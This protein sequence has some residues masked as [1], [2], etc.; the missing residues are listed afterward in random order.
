MFNKLF[1]KKSQEYKTGI[2]KLEGDR[3]VEFDN[4]PGDGSI[5]SIIISCG[6]E[7]SQVHIVLTFDSKVIEF[8]GFKIFSKEV[9]FAKVKQEKDNLDLK[10][11]KRE[12]AKIDWD[13]EYSSHTV[14]DILN[15]G[16]EA[17]SLS[18][19]F[20]SSVLELKK[21]GDS[22]YQSPQLELYLNFRTGKLENF[23]S[24]N[25]LN[26]DSQWLKKINNGM[27]DAILN[28]AFQYHFSE[29]EAMEEVNLQCLAIRKIPNAINN[30]FIPL[31]IK[32]NRNI[33]FYNLFV[34]HYDSNIYVDEFKIVNKGRFISRNEIT[35]EVDKFVFQF[36]SNGF[37]IKSQQI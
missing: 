3:L 5:N 18:F 16:I 1:G 30:E 8:I 29:I 32:P 24:L 6:Y 13:Y 19:E 34:T 28:E 33:N 10:V 9:V 37:L 35:L 7:L 11:L 15:N 17:N 14:L 23:T 25:W 36:D 22:L 2:F 4:L 27:F 20:L 31:H 26:A 12:I 21:D